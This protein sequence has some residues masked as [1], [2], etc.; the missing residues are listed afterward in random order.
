MKTATHPVSG[1]D[2]LCPKPKVS[3]LL[4]RVQNAFFLF[5]R[6]FLRGQI[7]LG[8]DWIPCS[9]KIMHELSGSGLLICSEYGNYSF[10]D[11]VPIHG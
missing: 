2:H 9:E 3:R 7:K 8:K 4:R 1:E 11:S 5:Y 10:H 6:P